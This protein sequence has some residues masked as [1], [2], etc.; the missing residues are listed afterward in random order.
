[1]TLVSESVRSRA[2]GDICDG[3]FTK[4]ECQ[5]NRVEDRWVC[6]DKIDIERHKNKIWV[7]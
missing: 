4:I 3:G 1:M 6:G 5:T 2:N 7:C